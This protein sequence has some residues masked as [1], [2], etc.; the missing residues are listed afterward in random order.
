MEATVR[1]FLI[2]QKCLILKQKTLKQ[3]IIHCA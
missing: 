1:Y 2:L 3:K